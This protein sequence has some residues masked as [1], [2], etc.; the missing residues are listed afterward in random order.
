MTQ[1][2]ITGGAGF[3]GSRLA[4]RL[5]ADGADVTVLDSLHPQVHAGGWPRLP[6]GVTAVPFDVTTTAPWDALFKSVQPEV[7]VHLAAETGT[8]QSLTESSRH[9]RVNVVGTTELLDGLSRAG[10]VPDRFVLA[11]SRAVYGEGTWATDDGA[12]F[13]AAPRGAAQLES[14]RWNPSAPGDPQAAVHALPHRAAVVEPRPSNIYAAT[15]LAQ[16][17]VLAAWADA[18]GADLAVL[19]LQNVYGPGQ[20]LT[21]PYTGIVSLFGR[22]ARRRE[23]IPVYEDG[24][25]IRDFVFVDDVVDALRRATTAPFHGILRADIGSGEPMPL[26]AL[27]QEIARQAGAPDPEVNGRYRL[28]DVRAAFADV[29]DAHDLLGYT[30]AVLPAE[31]TRRLLAWIGEQ[32][33][34]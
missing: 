24:D 18:R 20:S 33:I 27:A 17:H 23:A 2:L 30:P 12:P 16:E 13:A 21:N 26:L 14:A 5:V 6:A 10:H 31:G 1:V 25:I 19:R 22:L 9:G 28:G 15:K 29:T 3:I 8:G 7:I 32:G 4:A 11:S 34:D